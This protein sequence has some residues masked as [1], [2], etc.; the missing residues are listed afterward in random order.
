MKK[1]VKRHLTALLAAFVLCM[2]GFSMTAFAQSNEAEAAADPA[3]T[4]E[5]TAETTAP[6]EGTSEVAAG[7]EAATGGEPAAED[8][9]SGT[10]TEGTLTP[11]GNA[12]LIDN[13][14]GENKE[15]IT[16]TTKDGSYFYIL[17]DRASDGEN[18]VYFLNKVDAADLAALTED[19]G[20]KLTTIDPAAEA[21]CTCTEKCAAGAVNA[22]CAVCQNDRT[23]CEGK[24]V[25]E[26]EPPAATEPEEESANPMGLIAL[27]VIVVLAVGGAIY[28]FT[29]VRGK[30]AVKGDTELDEINLDDEFDTEIV[31]LDDL[32]DEDEESGGE[33][34]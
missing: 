29:V 6:A 9:P 10:D 23:K 33:K 26:T 27:G 1:N 4:Q 20:G 19:G 32:D 15:L 25:K 28:Y 2:G 8:T 5:A 11:D 21:E 31:E 18:N 22:D 17:I 14:Y 12:T 30:N 3:A 24:E 7:E 16:V 13:F 34:E